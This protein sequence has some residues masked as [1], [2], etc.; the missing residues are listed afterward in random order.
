[1]QIFWLGMVLGCGKWCLEDPN[2]CLGW[3][4]NFLEFFIFF[5]L[6]KFFDMDWS[7][8]EASNRFRTMLIM[9]G[10]LDYIILHVFSE[11]HFFVSYAN[12]SFGMVL[13]GS[14]RSFR[15]QAYRVRHHR[16]PNPTCLSRLSTPTWAYNRLF[17]S[18]EVW[19]GPVT[20]EWIIQSFWNWLQSKEV[21]KLVYSC[22]I[23]KAWKC[24][25]CSYCTFV[26]DEL[27]N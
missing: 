15:D 12:F 3:F 8:S 24:K 18:L 21:V 27:T 10:V 16:K 1:M 2:M 14:F 20:L 6:C 25:T 11:F 7:I 26:T 4:G 22:A 5:V 9:F 23:R 13:Q 17:T 19:N